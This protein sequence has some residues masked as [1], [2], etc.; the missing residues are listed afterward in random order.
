MTVPFGMSVRAVTVLLLEDISI[1]WMLRRIVALVG[2]ASA[3]GVHRAAVSDVLEQW[4]VLAEVRAD[5]HGV[6][7][8]F[9][10][11]QPA[12]VVDLSD[13]CVIKLIWRENL[14]SGA[15]YCRIVARDFEPGTEV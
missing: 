10:L 14:L 9:A 4:W 12:G 13:D 3:W 5:V 15:D 1:T 11:G 8:A 7:L 6:V 2:C